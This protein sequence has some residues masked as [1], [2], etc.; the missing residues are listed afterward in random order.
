MWLCI[1]VLHS[2]AIAPVNLCH[3][4][5]RRSSGCNGVPIQGTKSSFHYTGKHM[6]TKPQ[7]VT[8]LTSPRGY[9]SIHKR[10]A[11]GQAAMPPKLVSI[12]QNLVSSSHLCNPEILPIPECL[13]DSPP[14]QAT[15]DLWGGCLPLTSATTLSLLEYTCFRPQF[16]NVA[17]SR[18]LYP[19]PRQPPRHTLSS[20]GRPTPG[21]QNDIRSL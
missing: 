9:G 13:D 17:L 15:Q 7:P 11:N 19:Y 16:P 5:P 12:K 20:F 4:Q 21:S 2:V 3:T 14:Y 1:T 8:G 18:F 10:P 6:R